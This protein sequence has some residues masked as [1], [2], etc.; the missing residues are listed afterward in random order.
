[1]A[2]FLI[3]LLAAACAAPVEAQAPDRNSAVY[4]YQGADRVERLAERARSEGTLV[5]YTSLATSESVPLAQAFE[6]KYGVKVELWRS[7]SDQVMRRALNEARARRYNVDVIETNAP[8]LEALARERGWVKVRTE[9]WVRESD[10]V[11]VQG[12]GKSITAADL[13][14]Q[15]DRYRNQ[16]VRWVVQV[17]AYQT[18]DPLRKGLAPDEPY[19]LARGPGAESSLL[20]LALPPALV[21]EGRALPALATVEV[22]ARVRSGRSE[23]SGVPLLDVQTLTRRQ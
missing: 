17:I 2:R 4:L 3:L 9:G 22:Q 1:M 18:A 11:P 6:K 10:L 19:L 12:G 20:Y 14:A 8:E 21:E 16:S 7:L 15:P 5:V 13:R 23:P